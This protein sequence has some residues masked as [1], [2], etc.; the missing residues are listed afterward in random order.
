MK[1]SKMGLL[2]GILAV[3]SLFLVNVSKAME[4]DVPLEGIVTN[5]APVLGQWYGYYDEYRGPAGCFLT[6][7]NLAAQFNVPLL[8][9]YSAPGCDHCRVFAGQLNTPLVQNWMS[10]KNVLFLFTD[11]Q[12]NQ[13]GKDALR[14]I[15]P[16]DS[17]STTPVYRFYWKQADGTVRTIS[18]SFSTYS[19]QQFIDAMEGF[20]AGYDNTADLNPYEGGTFACEQ[21][22]EARLEMEAA[23]VRVYVPLMRTGASIEAL[24]ENRLVVAYPNGTVETNQVAW[25]AGQST[26]DIEVTTA[27]QWVEDGNIGLTL[28]DDHGAVIQQRMIV[29][30]EDLS[31]TCS[32]PKFIGE[33]FDFGEWTMDLDAATNQIA[34]TPGEAYTL[35]MFTGALWCPFCRGLEET[36]LNNPTNDAFIAFAQSNQISLVSIDNHRRDGTP[37]TLLRHEADRTNRTGRSGSPY[38][39]RHSIPSSVAKSLLDKNDALQTAWKLPGADAVKRISY[40]TLVLL[41]KDGSIA[42]RAALPNAGY[43]SDDRFYAYNISIIMQRLSELLTLV[44]DPQEELNNFA[45][46]TQDVLPSAFSAEQAGLPPAGSPGLLVVPPPASVFRTGELSA[47]DMR[48]VYRLE[49]LVPGV[50]QVIR[51]QGTDGA[52]P[53]GTV[54]LT[55]QGPKGESLGAPVTGSLANLGSVELSAKVN[56]PS[57]YFVEVR[58]S[59]TDALAFT[60]THPESTVRPYK[61]SSVFYLSPVESANTLTFT[62]SNQALQIKAVGGQTYRLVAG[63]GTDLALDG[64]P[65]SLGNG[66]YRWTSD[67]TF[68]LQ[69]LY[70]GSDTLTFQLWRPGAVGFDEAALSVGEGAGTA[71]LSVTRT[72]GGSGVCAALVS[73]DAAG[74]AVNGTHFDFPTNGVPMN[75]ADGETGP[76]TLTFPITDNLFYE[77]NLTVALLLTVT[78]GLTVATNEMAVVT[79][80]EDDQPVPGE[81]AFTDGVTYY[82]AKTSPLTLVATE[83]T[84]VALNVSRVNGM[85]SPAAANLLTTAGDLAVNRLEWLNNDPQAVKT[86]NLTLPS[87]ADSPGGVVKV[88]F[89]PEGIPAV[90]GRAILTIQLVAATAPSFAVNELLL[91]VQTKVSVQQEVDILSQGGAISVSLLSGKLPTGLK[92]KY[93]ARIGQFVISGIPSSLGAFSAVF[94]I[95]E[96]VG[97]ATIA[98]Q[99]L[100]VFGTVVDVRTLNPVVL[101]GQ[102]YANYAVLDTSSRRVVGLYSLT[103]SSSGRLSAKYQ[104]RDRA[105]SFSVN[106]WTGCDADTGLLSAR[107]V[108]RGGYETLVQMDVEGRMTATVVDPTLAPEATPEVNL[109]PVAWSSSL[110]ASDYEGYYTVS[111]SPSNVVGNAGCVAYGHSYMTLTLNQSAALNMGKVAYAGRLANGASY[112]GSVVLLPCDGA[113]AAEIG[114]FVKKG[115]DL[116]SG[117]LLIQALAKDTYILNPMVVLPSLGADVYWTHVETGRN[118]DASFD[119]QYE[120]FGAYYSSLDDLTY[121]SDLYEGSGPMML[122]AYTVDG[123]PASPAHGTLLVAPDLALTVSPTAIVLTPG[124]VDAAATRFSFSRSTGLFSGSCKLGM[125]AGT[126]VSASFAG[127]L[128]PGW[129]DC[130]CSV[131]GVIVTEK[132]FGL[133]AFWFKDTYTKPDSSKI[134]VTRGSPILIEK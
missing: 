119:M 106:S 92:G 97:R 24:Y 7:T 62:N 27:G 110:P 3:A 113:D 125:S 118:L 91:N 122:T 133:G 86:V 103:L 42:G 56:A 71:T 11:G 130:G 73:L 88:S 121:F 93:D 38:L 132:P 75:W 37:P 105:T 87:L 20:L 2:R 34:A 12:T 98:G 13:D 124:Q 107:I 83:G 10:T 94:Q 50:E 68:S 128:I 40:P 5:G 117:G 77:G 78:N 90:A 109:A 1:R 33:P 95:K 36:V 25:G 39:S 26:C 61:V 79:I 100:R 18:G 21:R 44:S 19:G 89:T 43:D 67:G 31:N 70:A 134:T 46:T 60:N 99:T 108:A 41:R 48:D 51:A 55:L 57:N 74:T 23:T 17:G 69:W 102:S 54:S 32:N 114:F 4:G 101:T 129:T 15:L 66:L 14:W 85:Q 49:N 16:L 84:T 111:L 126:T 29:C 28:L 120:P 65:E 59:T 82:F 80:V 30:V 131:E 116:L 22:E 8:V 96:R 47:S 64:S 58:A 53:G 81:L 115:K 45:V 76:K 72:D 9:L 35:V 104:N 63:N 127:V 123:F 112:S 6:Y 52:L